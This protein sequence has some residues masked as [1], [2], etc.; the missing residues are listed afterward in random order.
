MSVGIGLL[1]AG[2]VTLEGD[3]SLSTLGGHKDGVVMDNV[4]GIGGR[5]VSKVFIIS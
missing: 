1:L 4:A 5:E 3:T 2:M